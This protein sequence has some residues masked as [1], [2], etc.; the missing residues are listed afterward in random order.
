M[1]MK[2]NYNLKEIYNRIFLVTIK[3][4]YDLGMT[5]CRLQEYYESPFKQIRGQA[6]SLN[7]FQRLYSKK[8]GDGV[9]TYP[10]D[11]SGFNVPGNVVDEFMKTAFPDWNLDY[12]RV[13]EDIHWNVTKEY[14]E[15]DE[16]NPYYLIATEPKD[17]STIRHELCHALYYLDTEYRDK[18]NK[19]IGL[20]HRNIF[21]TFREHLLNIGYSKQ[22]ITDEINAYLCV[23]SYQL[24]DSLRKPNKKEKKNLDDTIAELKSLFNTALN[25]RKKK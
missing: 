6:F 4:P 20:L 19:T 10:I 5:F 11:W 9:F 3:D 16:V 12:D 14:E 13:I 21:A 8:F 24:T 2:I 15:Y 18:V 1:T 22:V 7:E 23:D 25:K 17:R